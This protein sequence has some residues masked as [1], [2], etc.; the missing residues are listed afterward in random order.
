MRNQILAFATT[1]L[2]VF[3]FLATTAR[4]SEGTLEVF[5]CSLIIRDHVLQRRNPLLLEIKDREVKIRKT[6]QLNDLQSIFSHDELTEIVRGSL[7]VM[8]TIVDHQGQSKLKLG[9]YQLRYQDIRHIDENSF[10]ISPAAENSS[11]YFAHPIVESMVKLKP[12]ETYN[13]DLKAAPM[14]SFG[15]GTYE[16]ANHVGLE[17]VHVRTE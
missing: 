3:P 9:F 14:S 15:I 17:C 8:G 13:L 10:W 4:A 1:L 6:D 7:Q 11:R 5:R 12:S 16:K 2:T